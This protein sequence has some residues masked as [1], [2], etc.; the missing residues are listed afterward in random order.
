M[1]RARLR[2]QAL[3]PDPATGGYLPMAGAVV[4]VY[5]RGTTTNIA[6]AMYATAT[7]TVPLANPLTADSNGIYEAYCPRPQRVTIVATAGSTTATDDDEF[8]ADSS[9]DAVTVQDFGAVGDAVKLS[10]VASTTRG[11]DIVTV[12]GAGFEAADVGKLLSL[13]DLGEATRVSTG[14]MT[15]GSPTLTASGAGFSSADL[16]KEIQV[17]NAGDYGDLFL[18]LRST[19]VSVTSSTEVTLADNAVRDTGSNK[20]VAYQHPTYT[21]TITA[22]L[23][24]TQVRMDAA[25]TTSMIGAEATWGTDDSDAIQAAITASTGAVELT[26]GASYL[27]AAQITGKSGLRLRSDKATLIRH[28]ALADAMLILPDG[29]SDV[30]L[31]G[32]ALDGQHVPFIPLVWLSNATSNVA[33]TDCEFRDL[34]PGQAIRLDAG[35]TKHVLFRLEGCEF[36]RRLP[37]QGAYY[38]DENLY[39]VGAFDVSFIAITKNKFQG[40]SA[41]EVIATTPAA[42]TSTSPMQSMEIS[43]NEFVDSYPTALWIGSE[44]GTYLQN[45]VA[46][47]NTFNNCGVW[48]EKGA[49]YG[50][51]AGTAANISYI[52]NKVRGGGYLGSSGGYA[53][54]NIAQLLAVDA[55]SSPAVTNLLILDNEI[56]GSSSDGTPPPER[57]MGI[58][59]TGD[60]ISGLYIERNKLRNIGWHGIHVY[61][62][63]TASIFDLQI[64]DNRVRVAACASNSTYQGA[65]I[66]L[67]EYLNRPVVA[68]NYCISNGV[69]ADL[70]D[71][72]GIAL[73]GWSPSANSGFG[74]ESRSDTILFAK[75]K[76][77]VCT[78]PS[79]TRQNNGIILGYSPG[80]AHHP[81]FVSFDGNEVANNVVGSIVWDRT[82]ERSHRFGRNP[83]FNTA[84]GVP[85]Y[86]GSLAYTGTATF[87]IPTDP[88]PFAFRLVATQVLGNSFARATYE[89]IRSDGGTPNQK[90]GTATTIEQGGTAPTIA[91]T[92]PSS[93]T[94]TVTNNHNNASSSSIRVHLIAET[95]GGV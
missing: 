41:V 16:G 89:G 80:G 79:G 73:G 15:S 64:I 33:V 6:E 91:S 95:W 5:R 62:T 51:H 52:A 69:A 10:N 25:P 40:V 87:T 61:G 75:L 82:T 76:G 49:L 11:S 78:D 34:G 81:T 8:T 13:K 12:S 59:V 28:P 27:V 46:G 35:S 68:G 63:S 29:T 84:L 37:R 31:D 88:N 36:N 71:G 43:N 7:G 77:N 42:C 23:S 70:V 47:G 3:K 32:V 45:A 65:G 58:Q 17:G 50:R 56:D 2:N 86:S 57:N 60:S 44:S 22:V 93:G 24:S 67:L 94:F 66:C 19:I 55:M 14:S 4:N 18:A 30:R 74:A 48:T 1:A 72:A 83:G 9:D 20:N 38:D 85:V 90:L 53:Q 92:T 26:N 39:T 21:G 54:G